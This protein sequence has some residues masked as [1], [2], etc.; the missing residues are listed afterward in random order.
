MR[1][2]AGLVV[3]L[4]LAAMSASNATEPFAG[5][6]RGGPATCRTPFTITEKS[7]TPPGGGTIRIV[8]VERDGNSYL[9]SFA[10]GYRVALF[11]VKGRSLTWHSPISGDTFEL[12]RC[13]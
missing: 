12:S 3:L 4:L 7:Y 9:L 1:G 8:K 6:W 13:K 11:S 5:R 2:W 10:D